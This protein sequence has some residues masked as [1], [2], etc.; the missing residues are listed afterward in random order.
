M[1]RPTTMTAMRMLLLTGAVAAAALLPLHRA[2]KTKEG[3]AELEK[4]QKQDAKIPHTWFNLGIVYKKDSEY[5]KAIQQL[6]GMT[7]LVPDEPKTHYNLA[8]LYKLNNKA[9]A[10][11]KEFEISAKLDPTL[12]GPHFQLYNAYRQ[13][14]RADDGARELKLFQ[15][16]KER[17]KGAAVP[18]DMEWSFFSEIYE[19]IESK[20][21]D[22]KPA[23]L[24][25]RDV[26]VHRK[27]DPKD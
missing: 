20:P 13:A 22:Q 5:D 4:A 23:E 10:A 1:G 17:T 8:V 14:G 21:T 2:A 12:A 16:I 24:K 3:I 18:E 27:L 9:D 15:A 25:F 6:E 19:T 26:A 7:K 11:L